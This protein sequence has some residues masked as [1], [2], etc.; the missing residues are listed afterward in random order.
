MT[1]R[2]AGRPG[3]GEE[4]HQHAKAQ[5]GQLQGQAPV[6]AVQKPPAHHPHRD[7]GRVGA[8]E[9]RAGVGRA[10]AGGEV[11]HEE[12]HHGVCRHEAEVG[13]HQQ[14][15]AAGF[16]RR[17]HLVPAGAL[18]VRGGQGCGQGAGAPAQ[19]HQEQKGRQHERRGQG[20][21]LAVAGQVRQ[22]HFHKGRHDG[23]GQQNGDG[24]QAEALGGLVARQKGHERA[25]EPVTTVTKPMPCRMRTQASSGML[26]AKG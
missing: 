11:A 6:Q 22:Q 20:V 3:V 19:G 2:Q 25:H 5:K 17:A 26:V 18:Q 8:G 23:V 1:S 7:G 4:R 10:Q 21:G 24:E 13:R 14:Q 16:E 15:H 9:E 12:E